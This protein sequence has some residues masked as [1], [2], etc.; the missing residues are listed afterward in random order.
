MNE[1]LKLIWELSEAQGPEFKTLKAS[2]VKLEPEER[3]KVMKSKAV[4]HFNGNGPVPAVWKA[5]VRGKTWFITN[6]HR[7]FQAKPTLQ[8]A[9]GAYHSFIKSTA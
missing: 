9:I 5:I 3:A 4:W 7:A 2:K 1:S 6:T 8:G